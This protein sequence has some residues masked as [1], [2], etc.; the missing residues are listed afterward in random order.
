MDE[1]LSED[2]ARA[3]VPLEPSRY[4]GLERAEALLVGGR[5]GDGLAALM[6]E[7]RVS[8]EA[9]ERRATWLAR[10]GSVDEARGIDLAIRSHR[11]VDGMPT[12]AGHAR[13]AFIARRHGDLDEALLELERAAAALRAGGA[14][15]GALRVEVWEVVMRL[16][17]R[18]EA[19]QLRAQA[20]CQLLPEGAARRTLEAW[21]AA[22]GGDPTD[23]LL[24]LAQAL[25][26]RVL[27][28][29][30]LAAGVILARD[31]EGRAAQERAQDQLLL[32]LE[33]L[34]LTLPS[35]LRA[36]LFEA[37][38]PSAGAPHR[39]KLV[40]PRPSDE[41]ARLS[42]LF[43][44]LTRLARE[45]ELPGL[46]ERITD[47]AVDLTGAER[48]FVLLSSTEGLTSKVQRRAGEDASGVC[49][50]TF[51]RSIA[52]SVI[53][54][55]RPI[56]TV[57]ART[58]ARLRDFESVHQLALTS[59]ACVPIRGRAG[60]L[61]ALY[62][63]HR[64][65]RARFDSDDLDL[66]LAFADQA[67]IALETH[68]TLRTLA[69]QRDRLLAQR[70]ELDAARVA[71][72]DALSRRTVEL[73]DTRRTLAKAS[74]P[75]LHGYESFGIVGSSAGLRR[76][77]ALV[78]RVRDVDLPVVFRGESGT[79]KELFARALHASGRR[80]TGPFVALSCGAVSETLL[81]SE[82]FG[83]ARGAF[84]GAVHARDGVFVR[85][86][87][88]TLFL[89]ELED[90]PSKM[91]VDLLRVLQEKRVRPLGADTD[92]PIDVRVVG[93]TRRPLRERV[94][95]GL[96]REDLL[97]RL[98]VVEITLPPLR[99]R[100]SDLALLAGDILRRFGEERAGPTPRLTA[101][102]LARLAASGLPG[103]VR[104]LEHLLLSASVLADGSVLDAP[105]FD[106]LLASPGGAAELPFSAPEGLTAVAV[107]SPEDAP[108]ARHPELAPPPATE[109]DW[110]AL[111]RERILAALEST[112]WN[113]ARA[114]SELGMPRRTFYR[115]LKE[116]GIL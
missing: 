25:P 38:G 20:V 14:P 81:E 44:T 70:D 112:S 41:R 23:A 116:H 71:L 51:S 27:G 68:Q 40:A 31:R 16:A 108:E 100:A 109:A 30:I 21:C 32:R 104:Q 97:Y 76:A 56:V 62:L 95:A 1:A 28:A 79:G 83:H 53:K 37:F 10:L 45:Q 107:G 49:D 87:G 57:D 2:W 58:D 9:A 82:L 106:A 35:R 114:A 43:Q 64:S 7:P 42:R 3:E 67:A 46:L 5:L 93:A 54:D 59:V 105:L 90:M 22:L 61:G 63:E 12:P 89:D 24:T 60:V 88:G 69:T 115:R 39:T 4:Q 96:F 85:A 103:N 102:A 80:R 78:D 101:P 19:D 92:V 8:G 113:R 66:L 99:E 34:G 6:G 33:E 36:G 47:G 73:A 74:N 75:S 13:S 84:T 65:R 26:Q 91:Q 55:A 48:G 50:A 52:E 98:Q 11:E 94:D 77:L 110:K 29:E 111:E 72:E 15:W 17:R 86:H 18:R